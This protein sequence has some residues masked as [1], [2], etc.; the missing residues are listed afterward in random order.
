MKKSFL[1]S[2]DGQGHNK[3]SSQDHSH[4]GPSSCPGTSQG[5]LAPSDAP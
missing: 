4:R 5:E 2:K 1:N 3:L